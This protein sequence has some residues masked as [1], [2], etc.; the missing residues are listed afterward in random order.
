MQNFSIIHN[1]QKNNIDH[2]FHRLA[3]SSDSY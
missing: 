1:L 3:S 2:S